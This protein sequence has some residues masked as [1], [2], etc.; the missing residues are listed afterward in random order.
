MSDLSFVE[1][2]KF[3]K[4]LRMDSGYVLDFSNRT[5]AEFIMDSTRLNIDDSRYDYGSGSKANRLRTFWQKEDN[6]VVGKLMND[7]LDLGNRTGEIEQDCRRIVARLLGKVPTAERN[8]DQSSGQ[9]IQN[10]HQRTESLRQLKDEFCSLAA[11]SNR[12]KAG[13]ALER[14]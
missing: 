10:Q 13:L 11:E 12:N 1:K 5:F 7:M 8:P 2:R 14:F 4:L 6:A 9:S 3:E